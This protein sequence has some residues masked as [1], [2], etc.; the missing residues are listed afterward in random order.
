MPQQTA[1]RAKTRKRG[2]VSGALLGKLERREKAK[3]TR[4]EKKRKGGW[5]PVVTHWGMLVMAFQADRRI[6]SG[7]PF[8]TRRFTLVVFPSV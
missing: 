8:R 4:D 2:R 1:A 6:A 5:L 3:K 7:M